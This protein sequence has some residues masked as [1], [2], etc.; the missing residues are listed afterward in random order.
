MLERSSA[1]LRKRMRT[2]RKKRSTLPLAA[3]S[4]TGAWQ[5]KHPMRVQ[6]CLISLD[7]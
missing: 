3:R 5:S 6:I 2:V 4:R 1:R 7:V